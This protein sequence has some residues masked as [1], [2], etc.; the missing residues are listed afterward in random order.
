MDR[1]QLA[2]TVELMHEV[3]PLPEH[4][5]MLLFQSVRELLLN[6]VKH[7]ESKEATVRLEI[8]DQVLRLHVR[9]NGK[10]F[11]PALASASAVS[12]SKFGLFSI[13]ERMKALGGGFEV[14]SAPGKGTSATLILPVH[15]TGRDDSIAQHPSF[16]TTPVM[17]GLDGTPRP[18]EQRSVKTKPIRVLL[19]D[20]HA[21]VRQGLRSVLDSYDDV[22]TVGEAQDGMEATALAAT[23]KPSVILMDIN[24]P[25]MNG[26][27]A[28]ARIKTLY[29]EI[30]IIGLSVNSERE[31][32]D[33]MKK[34]G[35][36]DLL[37][38]EAVVNDL[39]NAIRV[40]L[41][42]REEAL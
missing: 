10:G 37:P 8:A 9:D 15:E 24:M 16:T 27:E 17:P 34:A 4:H 6:T 3:P 12:T 40:A 26:I 36:A 21:M 35:A 11:D 29:P 32:Q 7:A 22:E 23:L 30:V 38:K 19:V 42:K 41:Q 13:R 39:H 20:D 1:H 28:S 5:A 2:V 18:G 25:R 33:A 31:N 14:T